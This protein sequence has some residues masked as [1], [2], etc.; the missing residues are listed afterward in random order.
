MPIQLSG[1]LAITGSITTST[2][3]GAQGAINTTNATNPTSFTSTASF[4]TDGGVRVAKD[5]FVSGTA[6]FNNMTVYGTQSVQYITSSQ[7][8]I[9]TNLI[10]VNTDTPAIR[11]GGLA[12]Y[13]S[14]STGLTG[15]M[16]WDSEANHWV[17]S[18]PSGSSYSGGMLISGPRSS[19][20]GSEQ[21]TTFNALMKGQGGDH[22]TSS[23]I[24]ESGS[25]VGIGTTSPTEKLSITSGNIQIS[26][27]YKLQY[28]ST[29]YIT[30]EDN[31]NGARIVT[32]GAL[33]IATGGTSVIMTVDGSGYVG[34]GSTSPSY[35]LDVQSSGSYAANF[36]QTTNNT[37]GAIRVTGN[38]RGGEIDFYSGSTALGGIWVD[39]SIGGNMHFALGSGFSEKMFISGS[40][41]VGIGT[42]SPNSMLNVVGNA[43][44]NGLTIKSAGNGGTFPFRVTWASGTDGS[45]FCVED[46]GRVGIGTTSPTRLLELYGAALTSDTPTLRI[47]SADS[48][49]TRKFGIEFYSRTGA[50]VR[51]KIMADNGG[52]LYID[53]NGGGGIILQANGGTGNVGIGTTSPQ[54]ALEVI[55]LSYFTRSSQSFLLNPNYG[56]S[57]THTQLQVVGNMALA[58]ATNGDNERMRIT[59]AGR[60]G[61]G[62]TA[63]VS[64]LVVSTP[65]DTNSIGQSG[66]VIQGSSTLTAGN[67]MALSFT[68]I[69]GT[70]RARAAVGSIVGSDWG[71]GN[72]TFYTRDA[73]DATALTTADERMRITS[74]GLV[75]IGTTNPL[76]RL[77]IQASEPTL[78]I[79]DSDDSGVM[80]IGN[81]GGFSYIRPFSRDFRFLN[82]A[83]SSLMAITSGGNVGIGTTSPSNLLSVGANAHTSPDETNRI[84]NWYSVGSE[85]HNSVIPAVIG[86]NNNSTSQPTMVG[87]S[88]FNRSTTDN[89]WSPAI[90]FGGLSTSAGYMNG[91]AGIAAQLPANSDGNFRGGNLVFYTSG[92]GAVKGLV[93]KM[94]IQHDGNVGIGTTSPSAKFQVTG[95]STVVNFQGSGSNIFTVDGT[96]GRLFSVDD[97][98]TNSL[99]SV[100]TIAGLPVI[101]AF[102]DNTVKLGTYS[103]A[104]GSTMIV[105]GSRVGIGTTSP[106]TP[107]QI[108]RDT[109]GNGT[110][111]EEANMAFT[112]LSA[113][114]QSKISIGASNAGNY[115]YV[116]VMQDATSWTSR[117]L[118]LQP[119]GGNVGIG[120]YTPAYRLEVSTDSAAKPS[121]NTWTIASDSRVKEN[122]R[123]YSKGLDALLQINPIE[124][125]YN[126]KANFI[127]GYGGIGIIAQDVLGIIPEG[128][129]TYFRKLNPEDEEDTELYNFNSHPLT[130]IMINAIKELKAEIEVLKNK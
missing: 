96:S 106:Q 22:I 91:A 34:I 103:A 89:T 50:D 19:A 61:I 40:G 3:I 10:S 114:G 55:G 95:S 116:Q 54:G 18:N 120:T 26:A 7:L 25:N 53:D 23:G 118:T 43:A 67:I 16:L 121:T 62:E 102:A 39:S 8:N 46:N 38:N 58:F 48:S 84:L 14:G 63:P 56:G 20:L 64:A 52:K 6:Y 24:F 77:H 41:L 68:A 127:Q 42:T 45:M 49:G 94:R 105:T 86:N 1:S 12:V 80:F 97:D 87:L 100:N 76:S 13:D 4:Y 85:L 29:A 2:T 15:S 69:P 128:V 117:N 57:G 112:V 75:G 59:N 11:F 44:T 32:P 31:T 129:S 81:T 111:I 110:N 28:S 78:R 122:I 36:Q 99:F 104:S 124:Y 9:G 37:Y 21:G 35:K 98:L 66:I 109:T 71:K 125:D 101:E 72:L 107:L 123:P 79:V 82:A 92:I 30:P 108:L 93:E 27:G 73:S 90:T 130:Y 33:N 17:Y 51:G 47:S 126:G 74:G 70:T 65:S 88:L 5:M 83:G 60:V 115:G 119:R 113:A